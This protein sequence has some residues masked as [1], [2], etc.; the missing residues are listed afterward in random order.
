MSSLKRLLWSTKKEQQKLYTAHRTRRKNDVES[1]CQ[2]TRC[3]PSI[4]FFKTSLRM[5]IHIHKNLIHKRKT[6][7]PLSKVCLF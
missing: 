7:N 5:M 4:S 3:G 6:N 2:N 1:V